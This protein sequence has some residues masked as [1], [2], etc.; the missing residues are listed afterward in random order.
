MILQAAPC[1]RA[2]IIDV[3]GGASTLVDDLLAADYGEVSLLDIFTAA[4]AVAQNRHDRAAFHFLTS[5]ADRERYVATVKCALKLGG[6][7]IM[8]TFA[9]DGPE[10]CSGP[11]CSSF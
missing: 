9:A 11:F 1:L 8:A 4:L 5:P 10:R 3:G 6:H 7:V 2:T